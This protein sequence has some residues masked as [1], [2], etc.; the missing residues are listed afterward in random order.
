MPVD[1]LR[2]FVTIEPLGV[3]PHGAGALH[4]GAP[5]LAVVETAAPVAVCVPLLQL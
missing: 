3:E 4:T 5:L 2:V 1:V